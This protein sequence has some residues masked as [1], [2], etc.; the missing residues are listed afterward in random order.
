MRGMGRAR[1][2]VFGRG[3]VYGGWRGSVGGEWLEVDERKVAL[4]QATIEVR[5]G[6]SNKTF[7]AG[8]SVIS[9]EMT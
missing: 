2:L 9:E 5:E 1:G 4:N 3:N 8:C 7:D 6:E